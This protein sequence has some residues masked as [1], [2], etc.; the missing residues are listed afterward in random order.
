[1]QRSHHRH[2]PFETTSQKPQV[3]G[4]R[5]NKSQT[6]QS[7]Q[8]SSEG[9]FRPINQCSNYAQR[10]ITQSPQRKVDIIKETASNK[11]SVTCWKTVDT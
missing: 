3:T 1:M 8:C 4:N 5:R 7:L 6:Q 9:I 11:K 10:D 2:Y